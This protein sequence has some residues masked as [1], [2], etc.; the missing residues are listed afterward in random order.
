M[1]RLE[2]AEIDHGLQNAHNLPFAMAF[3]RELLNFHG[4]G[5]WVKGYYT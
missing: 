1:G 4:A 5:W 2:L 3:K